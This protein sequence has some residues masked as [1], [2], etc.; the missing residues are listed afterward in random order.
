[1]TTQRWERYAP[2]T[3]VLAVVM[4][5]VGFLVMVSSGMVAQDASPEE[6]LAH[7][8]S[9]GGPVIAGS[10]VFMLGTLVFLW[11]LGSLVTSL[12]SAE[13]GVGSVA[14]IAFGGGLAMAV[15]ALLLPSGGVTLALAAGTMTATS[16]DALRHLPGVF[17][18][19]VELFA[20]VLVAA[21]GLVALRTAILP[22]VLAWVSLVLAVVLL[23]PPIGWAGVLLGF[24]VWVVAVSLLL[25]RTARTSVRPDAALP[26]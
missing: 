18:I 14:S 13:G 4:W 24:P 5:V 9:N 1:M 19:G 6:V 26:T 2:W 7:Y 11:F 8:Q 16:A 3:G 10:Y 20:T 23:I 12:R 25:T 22:R 21:T 15:C 17:Y